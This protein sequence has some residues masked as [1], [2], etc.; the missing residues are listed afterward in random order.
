MII[1]GCDDIRRSRHGDGQRCWRT[2]S[3]GWPVDLGGSSLHFGGDLGEGRTRRVRRQA[4]AVAS[5][6][7]RPGLFISMLPTRVALIRVNAASHRRV[8]L[9][10]DCRLSAACATTTIRWVAT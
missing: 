10:D 2:C 5:A 6:A 1:F 7:Q 4:N 3:A 9:A 8:R